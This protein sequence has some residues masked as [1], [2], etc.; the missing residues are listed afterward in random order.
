MRASSAKAKGRRAAAELRERL[1][2]AFP[3]L[4][5]EDI[6]VV[7]SGVVGED[8]WL[9]PQARK[10]IPFCFESKNQESLNIWSAMKQAAG[11]GK[12]PG[13][14]SFTR[15]REKMYVACDLETFLVLARRSD[16]LRR[17]EEADFGAAV[18]SKSGS[19]GA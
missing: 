18:G 5:P 6:H 15:N 9:S 8:L 12:Y 3:E 2:S 7:P 1:L 16:R 4:G 19:E 13:I 11:H 10:A 17:I 14:L